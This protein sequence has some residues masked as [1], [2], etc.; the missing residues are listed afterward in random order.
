MEATRDKVQIGITDADR[1]RRWAEV[2]GTALAAAIT[3]LGATS[4]AID[5][6]TH[7]ANDAFGNLEIFSTGA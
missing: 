2:Y 5:F 1:A 3:E 7:A 4:A 6:A